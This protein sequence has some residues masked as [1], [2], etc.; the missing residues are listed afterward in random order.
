MTGEA[1]EYIVLE[2]GREGEG[3]IEGVKEDR[4]QGGGQE[5]SGRGIEGGIKIAV[6]LSD[7]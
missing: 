1:G 4:R 6:S 7:S 2:T 3:V 5:A